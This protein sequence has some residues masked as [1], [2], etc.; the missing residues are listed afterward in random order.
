MKK[1]SRKFFAVFPLKVEFLGG[2][3]KIQCGEKLSTTQ[4][5]GH[6]EEETAGQALVQGTRYETMQSE[7]AGVF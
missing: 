7:C 1:I 2:I 5:S 4:L 6:G 3:L